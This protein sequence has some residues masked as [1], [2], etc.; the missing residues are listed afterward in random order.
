MRIQDSTLVCHGIIVNR[1]I[2]L[3][4]N[5]LK[6]GGVLSATLFSIYIDKLLLKLK[7]PGYGCHLNGIYIW[8]RLLMQMT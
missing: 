3:F 6:Q 5:G 1:N 4:S 8:E 7:E 2:F